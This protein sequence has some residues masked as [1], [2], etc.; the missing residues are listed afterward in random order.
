MSKSDNKNHIE[1]KHKFPLKLIFLFFHEADDPFPF[2]FP[3]LFFTFLS[4]YFHIAIS[5]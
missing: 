5:A 3:A 2:I 4:I 1:R